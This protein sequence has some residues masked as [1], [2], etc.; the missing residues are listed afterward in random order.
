MGV[1]RKKLERRAFLAGAAGLAVTR[2]AKAAALPVPPSGKMHFK[3]LRNG[4][5]IGEQH[6]A[7]V[8]SGDELNVQI[9]ADMLVRVAGIPVFRYQ[10]DAVERWNGG[11]FSG[12]DSKVNHNGSQYNVHASQIA[13]GFAVQATKAGDYQYTGSPEMMPMTYWNKAM[14]QSM[15]LNIESGRH[16]PASVSSP[17]WFH[18]PTADGSSVVA[19]RFDLS[20]K[21]NLTLWYDQNDQWSGMEFHVNGDEV[22]QKYLT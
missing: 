7:F 9:N 21:L 22:F 1:L 19:Q 2:P 13:G 10:V 6:M 16:Y 4:S 17:G 15:I 11:N 3:I 5:P 8:Q 14:M 12:L 20:G 18:L